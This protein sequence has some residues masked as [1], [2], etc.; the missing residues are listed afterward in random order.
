MRPK[1]FDYAAPTG[2]GDVL[3][4]L[5]G[6]DDTVLLAGG[7]SLVPELN[8]RRIAPR[9]VVD[10]NRVGELALAGVAGGRITLGALTRHRW[11]ETS[12][13]PVGRPTLPAMPTV[14]AEAAACVGDPAIRRRGTLGGTLAQAD[15]G[16]EIPAALAL[17]DA[18]V[19]IAGPGGV[20]QSDLPRL[21]GAAASDGGLASDELIT[22]VRLDVPAG[23][24]GGAYVEFAAT[25][26]GR[27]AGAG[28]VVAVAGGRCTMARVVLAGSARPCVLTAGELVGTTDPP[29][30]NRWAPEVRRLARDAGLVAD[31]DLLHLMST[32]AARALRIAWRRADQAGADQAGAGRGVPA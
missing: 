9:L 23:W 10:L 32:C 12:T 25:R 15:P 24:Q 7:Q 11:L 3:D 14:L 31:A 13:W 6:G 28:A 1:P 26:H 29:E 8:R 18:R 17:L 30:Q 19:E 16:A 20:R 21:Y 27:N 5:A 22:G 2:V 4:L